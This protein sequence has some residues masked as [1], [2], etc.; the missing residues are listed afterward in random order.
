MGNSTLS[1]AAPVLKAGTMNLCRILAGCLILAS[2]ISGCAAEPAVQPAI[3]EA[4]AKLSFVAWYTT[5]NMEVPMQGVLHFSASG[6]RMQADRMGLVFVQGSTVGVCQWHEDGPQCQ[7]SMP[8][9]AP[10]LEKTR[11]VVSRLARERGL[12]APAGKQDAEALRRCTVEESDGDGPTQLTCTL[13]ADARISVRLLTPHA[14]Q[15][16]DR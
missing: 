14:A 4:A 8:G 1:S 9:A 7:T 12:D 3:G 11:A 15:E 10:L 16:K 13:K 6:G 2:G 5:S